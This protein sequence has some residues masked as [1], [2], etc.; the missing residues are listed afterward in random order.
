MEWWVG[1]SIAAMFINSLKV[2]Y[3]KLK[4]T[5]IDTWQL[6][7]YARLFP[8]IILLFFLY[9]VDYHI[10]EPVT[11]WLTTITTALLTL[12]ASILYI[13]ALKTGYLSIIVPLQATIPLFMVVCTSVLY[14]EVPQ[15]HSLL[16][17]SIIV[18]STAM[19][20]ILVNR[21][22]KLQIYSNQPILL[23][24]ISSIIAAFLFGIST[25]LDRIAIAAVT[26][27]ALVYSAYWH[28]VTSLIL[29]PILYQKKL[30][31]LKIAH[32]QLIQHKKVILLYA[33]FALLAF[34]LQQLAVQQS[35]T[36][37]NGVTYVKTI[38]MMHISVVA[39]ASFIILK[40]RVNW[41]IALMS[42]ITFVSG[43]I[44]LINK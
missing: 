16:L 28:L 43:I 38:V 31:S 13:N 5:E 18:I 20:L 19:T 3:I 41:K 4:C 34:I 32:Y 24:V 14:Q 26:Q 36:I 40:E 7:F 21:D 1:L 37:A 35:L 12:L 30:F 10:L 44:L 39:L 15:F 23:S 2:L 11:F 17:I 9:F 29:L 33:L 27:G 8:A 6:V 25:V 22:K 42:T